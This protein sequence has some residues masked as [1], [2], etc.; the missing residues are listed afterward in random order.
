[1]DN[2]GNAILK[3]RKARK[4][5]QHELSDALGITQTHLSQVESGK[6]QPSLALIERVEYHFGIPVSVIMWAG[7]KENQV[8]IGKRESFRVLKPVIDDLIES[9]FFELP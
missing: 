8:S 7:V 4:V 2:I 9:L 1:M 3:I 6:K 5:T